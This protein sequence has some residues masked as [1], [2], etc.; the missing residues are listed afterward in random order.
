ME[1]DHG[2][3]LDEREEFVGDKLLLRFREAG[4]L[5]VNIDLA[6]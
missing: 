5:G 4:V 1:A 2:A 3:L 6:G